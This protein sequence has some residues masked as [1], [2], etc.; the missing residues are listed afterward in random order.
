MFATLHPKKSK[1]ERIGLTTKF[2]CQFCRF[3]V[4]AEKRRNEKLENLTDG[5]QITTSGGIPTV[6]SAVSGC[7]NCGSL[8]WSQKVPKGPIIR[9]EDRPWQSGRWMSK[10]SYKRF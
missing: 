2:R 8:N 4:D 1:G 6:V 3:P 7:P 5:I 9:P 10:H